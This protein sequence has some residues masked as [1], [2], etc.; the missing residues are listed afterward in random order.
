MGRW[1]ALGL[2]LSFVPAFILSMFEDW[3][4]IY[5]ANAVLIACAL[6]VIRRRKIFVT[7]LIGKLPSGFNWW[8]IVL[9]AVAMIPYAIGATAFIWVPITQ[10]SPELAEQIFPSGNTLPGAHLLIIAVV[11]APLVEEIIFRGLLFSRMV[12]KW[13][14]TRAMVISSLAFG[15]LHLDPIGAFVFGVVACV[16]YMKTRSLLVP[17]VL[18]AIYN[19][20]VW[21][22]TFVET[23]TDLPNTSP[24]Y[25]YQFAYVG[26]ASVILASPIIFFLLGKWWPSKRDPLPYDA[27]YNLSFRGNL[28][29]TQDDAVQPRLM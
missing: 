15:L 26:L 29:E 7:V 17:M 1:L 4:S 11:L 6:W 12:V 8:L 25:L 5:V 19:F 14:V 24:E 9:M 22:F 21:S 23:G 27:N 10:L 20:V 2:I 18:H 28:S 13:G 3:M 16:L